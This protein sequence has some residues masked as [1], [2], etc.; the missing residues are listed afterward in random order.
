MIDGAMDA[1]AWSCAMVAGLIQ[2]VPNVRELV[3]R[4]MRQAGAIIARRLA[5][6]IA[7]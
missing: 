4:I 6:M 3:K 2:D 5:G 7:A 1:G